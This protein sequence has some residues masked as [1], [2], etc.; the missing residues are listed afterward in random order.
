M[1]PGAV[2]DRDPGVQGLGRADDAERRRNRLLDAVDAALVELDDL[3]E[4]IGRPPREPRGE[5]ERET[6]ASE[7]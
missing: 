3:K 1:T 6:V 7:D 5:M 4:V 2:V